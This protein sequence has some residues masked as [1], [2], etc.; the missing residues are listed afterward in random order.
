M[1]KK[2]CAIGFIAHKSTTKNTPEESFDYDIN[3]ESGEILIRFDSKKILTYKDA[4]HH[5]LIL[6][7]TGS[8]KTASA[9]AP[10]LRAMMA[11]NFGGLIVDIKSNLVHTARLIA[12]SCGREQDIQELGSEKTATRINILQG[13]SVSEIHY[14]LTL[15][16]GHLSNESDHNRNFHMAGVS[17]AAQCAEV[18]L[19][20][21]EIDKKYTPTLQLLAEML[22]SPSEAT[23]LFVHFWENKEK[24][25]S[26]NY[27]LQYIDNCIARI[28]TDSHHVCMFPEAEAYKK[29]KVVREHGR[30][31]GGNSYNE[32]LNY[33]TRSLRNALNE[34]LTTP[35][36]VENFCHVD[37][38][39]KPFTMHD[40]YSKNAIIIVRFSPVSGPIGERFSRFLT[41]QYYKEVIKNGLML[42]EGKY[43][44]VC[45]DEFQCFADLSDSRYSDA[46]FISQAREFKNIFI[47]ATQSMSALMKNDGYKMRVDQFVSN[48]N[49]R[50]VFYSDDPF[51]QEMTKRYDANVALNE[52]EHSA[53][54]I[55]YDAQ[56]R[57]H[58][59]D[60]EYLQES[61][62][63]MQDIR[64]QITPPESFTMEEPNPY[65]MLVDLVQEL[66][67]PSDFEDIFPSFLEYT[68]EET[69]TATTPPPLK[70]KYDCLPITT[71]IEKENYVKKSPTLI[72][73]PLK[74]S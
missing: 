13:K 35:G 42:P 47:A 1:K 67:I 26:T 28:T 63:S 5:V 29:S 44:F 27:S 49:C 41:E 48:C 24:Y 60:I 19:I 46:S 38:E 14:F 39:Q 31:V 66:T 71:Y 6:G 3:A 4:S 22:N 61:Y 37:T 32:Q 68:E 12:K 50:I 52:L 54:V 21:S 8:G 15:L 11:S 65:C 30:R 34:C 43:T 55:T 56:Q 7:T 59:F 69:H 45:L 70:K 23:A 58:T 53:F 64:E 25:V 62:D 72:S 20:M 10:M 17:Q 74:N 36:I 57:Q 2:S 18:L 9:I 40:I 51:T 16:I 73:I 33:A